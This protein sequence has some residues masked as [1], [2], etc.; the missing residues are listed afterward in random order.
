MRCIK[1][2]K[3]H[4]GQENPQTPVLPIHSDIVAHV[5]TT[6]ARPWTCALCVTDE[7]IFFKKIPT[8]KFASMMS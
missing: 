1:R 6:G 2:R 8:Y 5:R 7:G 3:P 4:T